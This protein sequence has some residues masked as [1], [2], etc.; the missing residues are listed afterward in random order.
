[1][2]YEKIK[3]T[4]N[5]VAYNFIA[6]K[7]TWSHQRRKR[8]EKQKVNKLLLNDSDNSNETVEMEISNLDANCQKNQMDEIETSCT[9]NRV[10]TPD[11]ENA[12]NKLAEVRMTSP[13]GLKR[14][15]E[16]DE[17]TD[18]YYLHKRMKTNVGECNCHHDEFYLKVL[19]VIRNENN[20]VSVELSRIDGIE[21]REV[22]HQIMQYIKNNLKFVSEH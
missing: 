18:G 7:N 5:V 20:E 21:N 14:E 6:V 13:S 19:L 22:M 16:D 12:L 15:L 3:S 9:C 17:D 4:K 8:R 10:T 1:M 2:S 11:V